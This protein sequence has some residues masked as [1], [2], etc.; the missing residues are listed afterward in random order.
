MSLSLIAE[1]FGL[2][3]TYVSKFFKQ[4]SDTNVIDYIN[5]YRIDIAKPMLQDASVQEVSER[6][7]FLNANSFIRVFK[8]YEGITPG[9]Y[10]AKMADA[11]VMSK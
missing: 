2:H 10:K 1:Q 9:Q 11:A 8:K 6:V 4:Q 3:P 7:G 5:Q